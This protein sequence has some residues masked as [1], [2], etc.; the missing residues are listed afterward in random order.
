ANQTP[1]AAQSRPGRTDCAKAA[2]DTRQQRRP[3]E[4]TMELIQEKQKQ[5]FK[6]L[7]KDFGYKSVMQTPKIEKVV[8]SVGVGRIM[9]DK[10]KIKL[11]A[12]RLAKITGQKAATRGAKK[13]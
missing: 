9:K 3:Q 2:P 8:I 1:K 7:Q 11:V 10:E 5:V 12:D 4:I 13:S 6:D